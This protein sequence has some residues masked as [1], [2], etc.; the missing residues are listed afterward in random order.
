MSISHLY[1]LFGDVSIQDLCPF[2]KQSLCFIV[3]EFY[4]FFINF[5]YKPLIR[6]IICEYVQL[7]SGW[8]FYFVHSFLYSAKTFVDVAQVSI[9]ERIILSE[10]TQS[11]KDKYHLISFICGVYEQTELTNKRQTYR[12]Q[13]DS[14][15]GGV[16][17]GWS[18]KKKGSWTQRTVW[19]L[20][21]K[22]RV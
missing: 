22:R 20:W 14:L 3:I 6:Y 15:R 5:G 4:K 10:V 16:V 8:S 18:K 11:Q 2:C 9:M 7:F 19:W 21:G 1:V 13:A 17:Q 12:N